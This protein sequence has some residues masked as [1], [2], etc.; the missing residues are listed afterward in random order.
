MSESMVTNCPKCGTSFQVSAPQLAKAGGKVRCGACLHV[1]IASQNTDDGVPMVTDSVKQN[2]DDHSIPEP[3]VGELKNL[4]FDANSNSE[5]AIAASRKLK[6]V[7]DILGKE[8][9]KESKKTMP[10]KTHQ[11]PTISGLTDFTSDED[12]AVDFMFSGSD[13]NSEDME[14]VFDDDLSAPQNMPNTTAKETEKSPPKIEKS[15][16]MPASVASSLAKN[17]AKNKTTEGIDLNAGLTE[18]DAELDESEFT[19]EDGLNDLS[20]DQ[21]ANDDALSIDLDANEFILDDDFS[22]ALATS[23]NINTHSSEEEF[24]FID[25]PLEDSMSERRTEAEID[26]DFGGIF[27]EEVSDNNSE[28]GGIGEISADFMSAGS[29]GSIDPF[30]EEVVKAS[31]SIELTGKDEIDESWADALLAEEDKI[32]SR[33]PKKLEVVKAKPDPLRHV[34]RIE[35]A[36]I[37]IEMA[38]SRS[39]VNTFIWLLLSLLALLGLSVQYAL[40]NIDDLAKNPELRPLY[41]QWCKISECTLPSLVDTTKIKSRNL[42]LKPAAQT[43]KHQVVVIINNTANFE[44]PFPQLQLDFSD[45]QGRL[46][47]LEDILPQDYLTGDLKDLTAMPNNVDIQLSFTIDSPPK[48]MSSWQLKF[49]T[50]N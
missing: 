9:A 24:V 36:P 41:S 47:A 4:D 12:D 35:T 40:Y 16:A 27:D 48:G 33:I 15:A 21:I 19:F 45:T 1:F 2:L 13:E 46:V 22:D 5:G 39:W 50:P 7:P 25:N 38:Q 28:I 30:E 3:K 6:V 44:Q 34:N 8:S 10:K 29:D 49:K 17:I 42:K 11:E 26:D 32:Q 18:F 14:F 20:M 43:G 23:A 37:E 31:D